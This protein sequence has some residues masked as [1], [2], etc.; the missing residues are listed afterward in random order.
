MQSEFYIPF[1][2]MFSYRNIYLTLKLLLSEQN[3]RSDVPNKFTLAQNAHS[4][5]TLIY[6]INKQRVSMGRK[7][8]FLIITNYTVGLRLRAAINSYPFSPQLY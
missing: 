4:Y 5:L 3:P 8:A 7:R 2:F 6:D 1:N